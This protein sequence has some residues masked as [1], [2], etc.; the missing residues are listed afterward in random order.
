MRRALSVADVYNK[1][2]KL[3]DFTDEWYD[4][5]SRPEKCGVWFIWS[6]SGNGKTTFVL[7]LVK[8]LSTFAK[9]AIDSLEESD[10]HTMQEAYK[11]VN[12]NQTYK[13]KILLLCRERIEEL[14]ERLDMQKS[15]DIIVIDSF[16]YLGATWKEYLK[17]KERY[18]KKLFIFI[19]HADGK[20]PQGRTARAVM[21][22]A[23]LKIRIEGY[24]AFSKGRYIG[25]NGGKF[26]IW[27]EGAQKYWG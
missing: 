6:D 25:P 17:L 3:F 13:G 11:R 23:T 7:M 24:M 22:D 21:Y 12:M 16:Q 5:F 27:P 2:Y 26:T 8:Y 15:P 10:A 1:K 9:V 18:P 4:A 19:S 14:I 20:Q